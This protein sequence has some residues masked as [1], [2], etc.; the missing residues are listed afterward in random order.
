VLPTSDLAVGILLL[1]A[2]FA[3][4]VVGLAVNWAFRASPPVPVGNDVRAG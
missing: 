2:G 3:A 1:A 4:F